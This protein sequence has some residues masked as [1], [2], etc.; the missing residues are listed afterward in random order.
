MLP[1]AVP[2]AR[3]VK[4]RPTEMLCPAEMVLG[5]DNPAKVNSEFV[6][7]ADEIITLEP[8][9][10]RLAV[11]VLLLPTFTLPKFR[12][13][14]LELSCPPATPA[15][16]NAIVSEEFEA[17]EF[18]VIPPLELPPAFGVNATMKVT[19]SPLFK[20]TG[21]L[22]PLKLN[23]VPLTLACEIVRAELPVLVKVS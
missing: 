8:V 17:F 3:G 10:E 19:L 9:A 1:D 6:V 20:V 18:T 22:S 15:P 2:L 11:S 13:L 16:D 12:V 5:K 23:P 4:V 7:L 21:R 14:A